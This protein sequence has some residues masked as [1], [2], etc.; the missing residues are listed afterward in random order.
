[1]ALNIAIVGMGGIGNRHAK[2]YEKLKDKCKIVAVCDIIKEKADKAAA[3]YGV[4]GEVVTKPAQARAALERAVRANVEG[5]PY[6]LDIHVERR[7]LGAVSTW[8]PNYAIADL[9]R[10]KI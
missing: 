1:M 2:V 4:E 8:H 5:R 10:R 9:R 3:A 6:L 7:G